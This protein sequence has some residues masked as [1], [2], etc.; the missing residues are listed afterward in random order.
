M[1][2]LMGCAW[3]SSRPPKD[4]KTL[5]DPKAE[6]ASEDESETLNLKHDLDLQRLLK[7]SH[8]FER[9]RSTADATVTGPQRHRATDLRIQGLG[10]KGSLFEQEKMP[11]SHRKGMQG[12]KKMLDGKRREEAKEND[13]VLEKKQR[14]GFNTGKRERAVDAPGVGKFR[15]G[16]LKLSKSDIAG[17][18]G[19][20]RS[21]SRRRGKR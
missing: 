6:M 19:P 1:L 18:Q 5:A 4:S 7:E 12:K 3:Q 20:S 11:M 8:L 2:E 10:A 13:I 14:T 21:T 17:M 16:M 9:G 15:G